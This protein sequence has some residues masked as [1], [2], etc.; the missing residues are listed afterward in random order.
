MWKQQK[1][2]K[3]NPNHW[4]LTKTLPNPG[5]NEEHSRECKWWMEWAPKSWGRQ[6]TWMVSHTRSYECL[7]ELTWR[8]NV[9]ENMPM[10]KHGRMAYVF[11]FLLA[12]GVKMCFPKTDGFSNSNLGCHTLPIPCNNQPNHFLAVINDWVNETRKVV[13]TFDGFPLWHLAFPHWPQGLNN[14]PHLILRKSCPHLIICCI[15]IVGCGFFL[16]KLHIYMMLKL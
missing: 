1:N 16:I 4:T 15:D 7:R 13:D 2:S 3:S 11:G 6:K 12:Q 14:P 10:W 5:K 8:K 9:E